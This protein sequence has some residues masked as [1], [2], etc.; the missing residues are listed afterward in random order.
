VL[1]ILHATF[2]LALTFRL[3]F[4][5]ILYDYVNSHFG[6]SM[7]YLLFSLEKC[8]YHFAYFALFSDMFQV[9]IR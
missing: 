9:F 6:I 5:S 7:V 1:I 4:C 2:K 3:F 8:V